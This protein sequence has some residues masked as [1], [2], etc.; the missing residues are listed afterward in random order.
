[1]AGFGLG[2]SVRRSEG[3]RFLRG[4]SRFLDDLRIEGAAHAAFLRSPHAHAE[5]RGIE[6]RAAA[7]TPGVRAVFTGADLEADGIARLPCVADQWVELRREDGSPAVYPGRPLLAQGRVRHVGEAVALVVA[8][9]EAEALNALEAIAVEF[10]ALPLVAD[11]AAAA[12]PGAAQ[13]WAE[14]PGN[15]SFHWEHGDKAATD[16]AFAAAAHVVSLDLVNN[17][18]IVNPIETRGA[19]GLYDPTDGRYT[20]HTNGQHVYDTRRMSAHVLGIAEAD[21]RVLSYDVGGGFGI[22]YI[23]YPEQPLM[24]WAARKTGCP[25]KWMSGRAEAFLCD[26]HARD[27]VSHAELALDRDGRFL[28]IRVKTVAN[29][30]AY[31]SS[32]GPVCASILGTQLLTGGYTTPAFH[33]EVRGV[34]SNTVCVDAYRGAGQ[35]EATSCAGATSSRRSGCLIRRRAPSPTIRAISHTMWT[36][37][38]R[39]PIGPASP[40]AGNRVKPTGACGVSGWRAMWKRRPPIRWNPPTS[41]SMP[42]AR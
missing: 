14:A 26:A 30:G 12:E 11:T 25:V 36:L 41:P 9:G 15:V 40:N 1:M 38:R 3:E 33:A 17:R 37:A 21:L 2:A 29:L 22:K 18:V 32:H 7:A 16:T 31:A 19:I 6:T 27:H 39:S 28:A 34:F 42:T 23:T 4:S 24:L 13:I 35:P 20:L 8:D 5:I 10:Q